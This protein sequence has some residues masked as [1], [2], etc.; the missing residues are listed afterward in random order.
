MNC[1][2][3]RY[4]AAIGSKGGRKSRRQLDAEQ[5]RAMVKVR[6]ARRAYR[7]YHAQCFWSYP[8]DL[9]IGLDDVVW[10]AEQL[11]KHGGRRAWLKGAQLS[12]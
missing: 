9:V 7:A 12:R 5:A 11:M 3:R 1:Q 10:V 2:V 8:P 6:E 4:L